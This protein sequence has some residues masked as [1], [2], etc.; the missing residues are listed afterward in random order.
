MIV[1]PLALP[2]VAHLR[3]DSFR[4]ERGAFSR[5]WCRG[6]FLAAGLNFDPVQASLSETP[7]LRVL[8]GLHWQEPPYAETKVVRVLRGRIFDVVVDICRD[9]PSFGRH[10]GCD[11][12]AGEGLFPPGFAHGFLTQSEDVLLLYMMD[13]PHAAEAARGLRWDDPD[14]AIV[15]PATPD[16]V[17][18]RDRAWPPLRALA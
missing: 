17:G 16:V 5:L 12:R 7:G 9:S 13:A 14:L 8:R 11:L 6:E 2:G 15:W 3:S 18:A 1:T 4:D 10:I